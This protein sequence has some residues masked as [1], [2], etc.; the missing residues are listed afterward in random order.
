MREVDTDFIVERV[1]VRVL[2][3]FS[4]ISRA[5]RCGVVSRS[6]CVSL[7]LYVHICLG[8]QMIPWR[9]SELRRN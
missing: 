1:R 8:M 7:A 4:Q 5:V 2:R 3:L 9:D 6:L